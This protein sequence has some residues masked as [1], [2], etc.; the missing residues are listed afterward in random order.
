[1][2]RGPFA[3]SERAHRASFQTAQDRLVKGLRQVGA[4]DLKTAN[5]YL[6]QVYVPLW[7]RRFSREPRMA[8]DAHRPLHRETNLESVLSIR[9]AVP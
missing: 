1:M 2:D 4:Q 7:N 6:Q 5:Q 8:G 3:A 9:Q